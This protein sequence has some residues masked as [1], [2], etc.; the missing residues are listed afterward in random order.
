MIATSLYSFHPAVF[1]HED[2]E[3]S[4][5]NTSVFVEQPNKIKKYREVF[6]ESKDDRIDAFYIADYF[7]V[8]RNGVSI[9][10]EEQYVALQ[11]LTR[12]RPQFAEGY[13]RTKQHFTENSYY[14]CSTMPTEL[15][16]DHQKTS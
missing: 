12:T 3:L 15:K 7:R 1:F 9:L 5:L 2:P 16:S 6:E 14:K 10:K 8:N 4:A 13:V 11:H